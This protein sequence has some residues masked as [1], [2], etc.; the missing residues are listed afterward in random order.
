MD[1]G[2]HGSKSRK[3]YGESRK[4]DHPKLFDENGHS[5]R[6]ELADLEESSKSSSTSG[7]EFSQYE[8]LKGPRVFARSNR[9]D[10]ETMADVTAKVKQIEL[11]DLR[12]SKLLRK[13]RSETDEE[14][15][16]D[17]CAKLRKSIMDPANSFYIYKSF[18]LLVDDLLYIMGH[19]A[20]TQ[21]PLISEIFGMI[22]FVIRTDFQ[23]YK[24]VICKTYKGVKY[25]KIPMMNA[26][27]KTLK[28][29]EIT[30]DL[31]DQISRLMELLRDFLEGAESADTFMAITN[32]ILVI[33]KNYPKHFQT[34]F[35]NIVDIVVG[36]HLETEQ[37]QAVKR[38]CSIVLQNFKMFFEK[39]MQFT[40]DLLGQILEDIEGYS[41]K[42]ENETSARDFGSHLCV[43]NTI[44]K[45]IYASP[46][47]LWEHIGDKL[48]DENIERMV[49]ISC[50]AVSL[51]EE[52][53]IILPVN[54][55]LLLYLESCK[56]SENQKENI[57]KL[58]FQQYKSLENHRDYVIA[59]FLSLLAK[60]IDRFKSKL[61][62]E[63]LRKFMDSKSILLLKIRYN[64]N[65]QIQKGLVK[66]F[67][68]IFNIKNVP[69]LQEAYRN[70]LIDLGDCLKVLTDIEW[71]LGTSDVRKTEIQAK[72][73]INFCLMV[74]SKLA[75]TQNSI[76]AMYALQ[77]SL[78]EVLAFKLH[79][80]DLNLWKKLDIQRIAILKLLIV[81]CQKNHN[82]VS[83]SLLFAS[84]TTSLTSWS[85]ESSSSS[86]PV[87]SHFKLIL[88]FI[89]KTL[90]VE[91]KSNLLVLDWFNSLI[92]Q[93]A[94]Y[95]A[96][97]K[98]NQTFNSVIKFMNTL[99]ARSD[100]DIILK[101]VSCL[102]SL[103]AFESLHHELF[104]S[105]AEICCVQICSVWEEVRN[106][107][108]MIFSKLPL[109]YCLEQANY[110]TGE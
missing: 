78:L 25:L 29:D 62:I 42:L 71:T 18:D 94:Q 31:V 103:V 77:P 102:E 47:F 93:T 54:E 98:D 106:R 28:L 40:L 49:S 16:V 89:E 101:C 51:C 107:Y 55:F 6:Q 59:S 97:L 82:F 57:E 109:L 26:L 32:V 20:K 11:E 76:I 15:V 8:I 80:S 5:S 79:I 52:S 50:S 41:E 83:S 87:S 72:Y 46:E 70:V 27:E 58:I 69:L 60:F 104:T 36:W 21:I 63:F 64:Q 14:L 7:K 24:S 110:A 53:E 33:S 43:C 65:T 22:G 17:L 81:H 91:T 88:E 66:V 90:R 3:K 100:K 19:C 48:N 99:S 39:D 67:Q 30:L 34:H 38:H 9:I 56:T 96:L 92:Q 86:S 35:L 85:T 44:L 4:F 45:C 75:S 23:I 13:L 105:I 1:R 84:K 74:L 73:S 37:T 10:K 108:S 12:I 61:E 68:E 95:H 2:D